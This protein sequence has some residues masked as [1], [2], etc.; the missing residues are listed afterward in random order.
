MSGEGIKSDNSIVNRV[1]PLITVEQL[2]KRYVFGIDTTDGQGNELPDEVWQSYIETAVS[3]LEHDLDINIVPKKY[4]G[5]CAE[6]K[7]YYAN[8]YLQWGYFRLNN[9]PVISIEKFCAVYPSSPV[10]DYPLEWL[11]LQKHDGI[12]RIIPT[13]G[14]TAQFMVGAAG[15]FV[16]ELFRN[17]GTVPLL[18]EFEY[19]AG[20]E[21]GKV[22]HL[23]N[24]AI[25]L[26]AAMIAL[27]NLAD[28]LLGTG[29]SSQS[30]S[31]D[32]MSQSVSLT[33]SAENSTNSAKLKAY[34][35]MLFGPSI[36]SPDQG[37]IRVLRNY[38]KGAGMT[39]L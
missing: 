17:Q 18:W 1:E 35:T 16:P 26:L 10:I 9:I 25:G 24:T 21:A 31:L 22:P 32:G 7:D 2:K 33:A 15:A 19:T 27:N 36:G 30:I 29:I 6:K 38:Y 8:D 39:I 34:H 28:L 37:I 20:F 12:V 11:R 3:M 14:F 13:G 23:I 5:D 4:A